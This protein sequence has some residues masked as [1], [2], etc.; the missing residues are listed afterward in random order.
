MY[1]ETEPAFEGAN[2][3]FEKVGIFVE[4]DGFEGK[5]SETLSSVCVC[6]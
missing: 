6:G 2:V 5:F 4:I 3:V 1:C